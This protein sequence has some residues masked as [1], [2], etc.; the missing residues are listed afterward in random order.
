MGTL[1][2]NFGLE[3]SCRDNGIL[4]ERANVGDRYVLEKLK[5]NHWLLGGE[6]SG[7]I[8]C[9]DK[10]TTGDGIVAALEMLLCMMSSGK[11]LSV[12][13][14]GMD[15]YPQTMVNIKLPENCERHTV[16]SLEFDKGVQGAMQ[17]AQQELSDEGRIVLRPSGTEP[18]IR[19]MVEGQEEEMVTRIGRNLASAV[20]SAIAKAEF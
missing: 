14:A 7:H 4:F 9:L 16:E 8:I 3:K 11:S 20:E 6:A 13:K 17:A 10:S 12:L 1:M 5:K 18:L 15:I 2:S 19:I